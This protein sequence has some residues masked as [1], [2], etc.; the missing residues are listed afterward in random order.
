M[1]T[2]QV[3]RQVR[4]PVRTVAA[5]ARTVR[6]AVT[7]S[8]SVGVSR[9]VRW[10]IAAAA[11]VG[12]TVVYTVAAVSGPDPAYLETDPFVRA[13][14]DYLTLGAARVSWELSPRFFAPGPYV[15]QLQSSPTD[16][17]IA[18][19]WVTVGAPTTD[20][21]SL[22]DS[23][24]NREHGKARLT[25]YRVLLTDGVGARHV[26]APVN[27]LGDLDWRDWRIGREVI[28]KERLRHRWQTSPAGFLYKRRRAGP[29]CTRCFDAA[30]AAATDSKCPVCL[31]TGRVGGYYAPLPCYADVSQEETDEHRSPQG[32]GMT[33]PAIVRG[34]FIGWPTPA[35]L[36]V[37]VNASADL[38]YVIGGA[39]D[40]A[41]VKVEAQIRGVPLVF[42]VGLR[43][44]P[45][46][47]V[48]YT[49]PA[50]GGG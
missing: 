26:S 20:G 11:G 28:R 32:A 23:R 38:R 5:A 33:M 24:P 1:P 8:G 17:S 16:V 49:L 13:T 31:G 48:A 34:R 37:W 15:F 50:P 45:P 47:D 40:G 2:V 30:T 3:N 22:T 14:V 36:D 27:T 6:F 19:D 9:T 7:G 42:T 41:G 10:P 25:G 4:W 21:T 43:R 18:D 39:G 12:G 35:A 44:L 46:E 29:A